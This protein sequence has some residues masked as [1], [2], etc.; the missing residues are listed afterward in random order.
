MYAELPE[1]FKERIWI[2]PN[3]SCWIW[4][5]GDGTRRY[6][7]HR[8][9]YERLVG[10]IPAKHVLDHKCRTELCVNPAHLEPVT[11][12]VNIHRK[13]LPTACRQGHVWT[14]ETKQVR[15]D[16]T[17]YCRV[18]QNARR[19]AVTILPPTGQ[20]THCPQGHFYDE[21]NTSVRSNGWRRC[22]ACH[23]EAERNAKRWRA[24]AGQ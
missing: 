19:R 6:G 2:E 21:A 5:S 4:V 11:Q 20:R 17:F 1:R 12:L 13:P 22:K 16:G 14:P 3:T 18:C 23:R 7:P 8:K 15:S 9:V 10:P 24:H